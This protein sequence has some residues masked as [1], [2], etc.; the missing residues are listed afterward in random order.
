MQLT[1][2]EG[3][4]RALA[5]LS[6]GESARPWGSAYFGGITYR[7]VAAILEQPEGTVPSHMQA[8]L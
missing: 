3:V 1:E 2:A 7:D 6:E 8:F 5:T 4:R